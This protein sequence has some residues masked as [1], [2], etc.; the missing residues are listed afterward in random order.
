ML[1]PSA[2][3]GVWSEFYNPELRAI[4]ARVAP[5]L[6]TFL[7]SAVG[8]EAVRA[9]PADLPNSVSDFV[10]AH[11]RASSRFWTRLI[12]TLT[13]ADYLADGMR[14]LLIQRVPLGRSRNLAMSRVAALHPF[15]P[16]PAP[17]V[18]EEA[19]CAALG[20]RVGMHSYWQFYLPAVL[21]ATT[22]I[23]M[24]ARQPGTLLRLVGAALVEGAEQAGFM[25]AM[26]EGARRLGLPERAPSADTADGATRSVSSAVDAAVDE[27]TGTFGRT[28]LAEVARGAAAATLLTAQAH[29]DVRA[30]LL[31]LSD[32]P[33]YVAAARAINRRIDQ[34]CPDIDRETFVEPRE[35]CSTTHVHDD[36]R[37]VVIE[38]GQM[39]FWGNLGMSLRLDV[40]DMVLVPQGR[41]HGSTVESPVCTYHQPIIP[42]D[43]LDML[44]GHVISP[45]ASSPSLAVAWD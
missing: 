31:W 30:Q 37:L 20:V 16:V 2:S 6:E 36:H 12:D 5:R 45:Y 7:F 13:A 18:A 19:W 1:S 14:L 35:M 8:E 28:S 27:V 40:G 9:T 44:P 24:L 15:I 4:G 33:R 29:R 3:Q 42:P 41:L 23:H 34:D 17:S 32:M 10:G 25:M 21:A 11:F 39:V 43:W 38:E 22:H 26:A